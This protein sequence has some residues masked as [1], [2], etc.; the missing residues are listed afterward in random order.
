MR[1][2]IRDIVACIAFGNIVYAHAR[3]DVTKADISPSGR[4]YR[5]AL[6]RPAIAYFS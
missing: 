4:L 6:L 1:A 5:L 2:S 3:G